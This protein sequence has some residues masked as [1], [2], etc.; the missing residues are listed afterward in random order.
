[1]AG[2][3]DYIADVPDSSPDSDPSKEPKKEGKKKQERTADEVR[4]EVLRKQEKDKAEI[5][6]KLADLS[7]QIGQSTQFRQEPAPTPGNTGTKKLEEMSSAELAQFQSALDWEKVSDA[8]KLDFKI[9]VASKQQEEKFG[10]Q[11]KSLQKSQKLDAERQKYADIAKTRYPDLQKKGSDLAREVDTRLQALS[12]TIVLSN[13]SVVL[14]LANE[15]A[16]Q[17]NI[18]PET[19]RIVEGLG[20]PAGSRTASAGTEDDEPEGMMDDDQRAALA[21]A[22]ERRNALPKGQKFDLD[23]IKEEEKRVRKDIGLHIKEA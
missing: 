3:N 2:L 6:G 1:M 5:M 22:F 21:K 16:I 18:R 10:T 12:E 4:G 20:R 17:K 15:V 11:L 19:R 14:D 13:P 7:I 23:E 8:D 9:L